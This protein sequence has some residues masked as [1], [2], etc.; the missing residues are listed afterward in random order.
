MSEKPFNRIVKGVHS[1]V[2][3]EIEWIREFCAKHTESPIETILATAIFMYGRFCQGGSI[4]IITAPEVNLTPWGS[5]RFEFQKEIGDYRAD[6]LLTMWSGDRPTCLVV[7]CDGHD[8]HERTKEQAARDRSRDRQMTLAGYKVLR[9]TG[10]EIFR[11]PIKCAD[12]IF[13]WVWG[14]LGARDVLEG[15]F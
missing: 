6:F 4:Q 8:F 3:S 5:V 1:Y 12:Q 13:E 7:E 14:A 2:D 10:S 9:F 11:D 15:K